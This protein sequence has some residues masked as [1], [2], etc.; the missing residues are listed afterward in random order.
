[1]RPDHKRTPA[2]LKAKYPYMFSKEILGVSLTHG[3]IDLFAR[4]CDDVDAL[5]GQQ[6]HRFYWTQV[7]EK[8]GSA[9]FYW[10]FGRYEPQ[11]NLDILGPGAIVNVKVPSVRRQRAENSDDAL[12]Q[13]IS[14]LVNEAE[15]KTRQTCIACGEPGQIDSTRGYLLVLCEEHRQQRKA[16]TLANYSCEPL[17]RGGYGAPGGLCDE[18]SG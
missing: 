1:M 15:R 10:R 11:V 5:L 18:A 16:G 8:F 6:K 12:M 2:E 17:E 7:K 3:W 4:L 14:E 9:R 13:Q